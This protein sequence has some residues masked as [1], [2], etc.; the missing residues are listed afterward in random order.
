MIPI[1]LVEKKDL[2]IKIEKKYKVNTGE[3]RCARKF[4]LKLI[5]G[6]AHEE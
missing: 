5:E 6:L 3:G 2:L 4:V 1:W